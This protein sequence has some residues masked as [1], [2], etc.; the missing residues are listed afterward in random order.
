MTDDYILYVGGADPRKNLKRLLEAFSV[1]AQKGCPVSLVMAG[2]LGKKEG[3]ILKWIEQLGLSRE[4]LLAGPVHRRE[5]P[6]LYS[7][8]RLFVYPS[9]YEGFGLPVL[10]A[11]ACGVSVITSNVSSL[12]EVAGGAAYLVDPDDVPGLAQAMEAI[13]QDAGLSEILRQPGLRLSD[14]GSDQTA[15]I[16]SCGSRPFACARL[17]LRE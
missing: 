4:V 3:E 2:G 7:G 5:L 17:C 12:P 15:G 10:E 6:S 9:L 1:L 16:G 14:R 13:L 11:M 8:A